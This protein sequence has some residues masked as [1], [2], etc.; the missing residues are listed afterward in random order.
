MDIGSPRGEHKELGCSFNLIN[1]FKDEV[2]SLETKLT[3]SIYHT[4]FNVFIIFNDSAGM[5]SGVYFVAISIST[6]YMIAVIAF[7]S[8]IFIAILF[9]FELY[10][11]IQQ[12][13][14]E[15]EEKINNNRQCLKK[16]E[17]ANNLHITEIIGVLKNREHNNEILYFNENGKDLIVKYNDP[18]LFGEAIF[19]L[20]PSDI[21]ATQNFSPKPWKIRALITVVTSS[22]IIFT[23]GKLIL[24]SSFIGM[25]ITGVPGIMIISAI[26]LF[27]ALPIAVAQRKINKKKENSL[28]DLSEVEQK[29]NKN[30]TAKVT[31]LMQ[32]KQFSST[33]KVNQQF[34]FNDD[35]SSA[36]PS[37]SI[38]ISPL[39]TQNKNFFFYFKKNINK[40]PEQTLPEWPK[41][42]FSPIGAKPS[43]SNEAKYSPLFR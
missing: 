21:I 42:S 5:A 7:C 31:A 43:D 28:N 33:G 15:T 17:D 38:S 8:F 22:A 25:S 41:R 1:E 39:Q 40:E 2:N 36:N 18:K 32:F 3:P 29:I 12:E 6:A 30:S 14:K 23:L 19:D 20:I 24:A 26:L 37:S 9:S 34:T 11:A 4:L 16:W 10:R 27:Y 13:R 35:F